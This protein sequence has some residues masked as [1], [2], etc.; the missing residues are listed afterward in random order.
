MEFAVDDAVFGLSVHQEDFFLFSLDCTVLQISSPEENVRERKRE[1]F[2]FFSVNKTSAF[3][4]SSAGSGV[5][6]PLP[7]DLLS[8]LF[9]LLSVL[10]LSW[11]LLLSRQ[12]AERTERICTTMMGGGGGVSQH[13]S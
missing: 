6:A 5:A 12:L 3:L 9:L 13:L 8:F 10:L 1:A 7:G 4:V 11:A 2:A